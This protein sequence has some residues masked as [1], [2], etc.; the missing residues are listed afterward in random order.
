MAITRE[1]KEQIIEE[2]KKDVE[3][4]NVLVFSDF[5]GV[6]V[7]EMRELRVAL[8]ETG[9]KFKVIKKRLLGLI[10]KD[11]GIDFDTTELD[12]QIGIAFTKGEISEA[13]QP[14]FKFAKE[15]ETFKIVGGVNVDEKKRIP[16]EM[17]ITISNLPSREVLL[18][19][20]VGSI[21]A[22]LRGFMHVLKAKSEK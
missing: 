6:K 2:G 10:L 19:S 16:L 11:S 8:R 5:N 14:V 18:A 3:N 17:I 21:A 12:G 9:A 22:P 1:K 4:S 20:V 13:A 15:H 7:D